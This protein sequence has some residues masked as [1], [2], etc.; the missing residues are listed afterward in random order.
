MTSILLTHGHF[1]HILALREIKEYT[2]APVYVHRL[3]APCL[4][5]PEFSMMSLVGRSDTFD[6]AD[7][8]LEDN[9]TIRI[10]NSTVTVMYTPGHTVGS[11]CYITDAGI[12][13]G[14]T[15]FYESIGRTDF[16]GGDFDSIDASIQRIYSREGD[17][18]LYP[19]H[20]AETT[21]SHER[22]FNPFVRQR[23]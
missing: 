7:V 21:V 22:M 10:G 13:S 20:G 11:V 2:N 1:D 15:L 6:P 23:K 17:E 12:I 9:D 16:P 8:L 4:T 14:D 18:T 3:D 5:N 19:G